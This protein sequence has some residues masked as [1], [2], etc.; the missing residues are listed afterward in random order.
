MQFKINLATRHYIDAF[1]LNSALITC[2]VVLVVLMFVNILYVAKNAGELKRIAGETNFL[3]E[4]SGTGGKVIP[5]TEYKTLLARI[6]FANTLIEKKTFNWL[7]FLN[8][9]EEVVPDGVAISLIEPDVKAKTLK[10]SGTTRSFSSLRRLLENMEKST[11]Y[12]EIYLLSQGELKVGL[13][14][15]GINFSLSCR[16]DYK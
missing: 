15:K 8:R 12:S 6:Q 13:S 2:I 1:K 11:D 5:E 3:Q 16:T 9:L 10:L 4:K 14:Q 7:L